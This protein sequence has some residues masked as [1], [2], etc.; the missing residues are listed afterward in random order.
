LIAGS[1]PA[2]EPEYRKFVESTGFDYR[3]DLQRLAGSFSTAGTF[4]ILSGRFDWKRLEAYAKAQGGSCR[5]G[6]CRTAS[7]QPGRWIS[8]YLV[9]PQTLGIA[10]SG[11]EF[12]ALEI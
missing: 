8:F 10:F 2:E 5:D 3:R 1:K 11:N 4:F 7:S 9:R 6:L 12:A